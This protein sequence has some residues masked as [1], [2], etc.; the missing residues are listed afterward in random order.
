MNFTK[1][2]KKS[3]NDCYNR[4]H[5][6]FL[7]SFCASKLLPHADDDYSD[8]EFVGRVADVYKAYPLIGE[9]AVEF[10]ETVT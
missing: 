9:S 6:I 2:L 5:S 10:D 8:A 7:L 1:E 4:L 3:Q